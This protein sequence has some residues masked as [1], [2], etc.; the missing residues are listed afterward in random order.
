MKK[1]L[2]VSAAEINDA[3]QCAQESAANAVEHAIRCG[4]L[5]LAKQDQLGHGGFHSW[6]EGNCDFALSTA[7]R[8]ITAAKKKATGVAVPSL[9]GIFPSGQ[10]GAK[11]NTPKGAVSVMNREGGRTTAAKERTE[12]TGNDRPAAPVSKLH[13][14]VQTEQ[15]VTD[16]HWVPDDDEDEKLALAEKEYSAS[17][18]KVMESDDKLAA[19]RA[20]IKR[21]AAEIATLRVS[22]DGYMN[23]KLAV[24]KM[25][26]TEQRKV[27]R[28]TAELDKLRGKAA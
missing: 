28:L 1:Q 27:E 8:Y 23:G 20:E 15:P 2:P 3:H 9:S 18:D 16:D 10:P 25:L 6:I 14:P 26:K 24:T 21:Q 4:E 17:I 7:K 19:A 11:S 22:R 5:L 12:E 13:A